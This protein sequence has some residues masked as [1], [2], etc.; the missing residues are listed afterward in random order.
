MK[1]NNFRTRKLIRHCD[2][3][4]PVSLR[5]K[6]AANMIQ[7][8]YMYPIKEIPPRYI[9]V[10]RRIHTLFTICRRRWFLVAV[11]DR[12]IYSLELYSREKSREQREVVAAGSAEPDQLDRQTRNND[13]KFGKDASTRHS[14]EG[15][16]LTVYISIT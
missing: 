1:K 2:D 14:I 7:T 6:P 16:F 15:P 4:Q 12:P 9:N 10:A 8:V 13:A 3:A 11:L 5:T